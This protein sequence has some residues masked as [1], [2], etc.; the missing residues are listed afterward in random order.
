MFG[1]FPAALLGIWHWQTAAMFGEFSVLAPF[2]CLSAASSDLA[3][4]LAVRVSR[5]MAQNQCHL[6]RTTSLKLCQVVDDGPFLCG[7]VA[8]RALHGPVP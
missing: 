4:H 6:M 2:E 5:R 7:C 8:R 1:N 3:R